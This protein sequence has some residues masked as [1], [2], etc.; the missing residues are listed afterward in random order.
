ML[1]FDLLSDK[2]LGEITAYIAGLEWED[3]KDTAIGTA[4][5]IKNNKQIT[6][7]NARAVP[8]FNDI[9]K[10][11]NNN[12]LTHYAAINKVLSPRVAR[13]GPGQYYGWHVDLAI[14]D[15]FRSDISFTIFLN[16]DYEGGELE[17]QEG[18]SIIKVRGKA[19]QVVTYPTSLL[20]R[21]TEVTK[22]ERLVIVGWINSHIRSHD[23]RMGLYN[24]NKVMEMMDPI[25]DEKKLNYCRQIFQ[26]FRRTT[27]S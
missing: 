15:G 24:L 27:S 20:H 6:T 11:F 19:G 1:K 13:Y 12:K 2:Q 10:I 17:L 14:I 7:L 8:L 5:D 26:H 22:G 25:V 4:K 16:D 18:S 21:V 3:G 23:D 9:L